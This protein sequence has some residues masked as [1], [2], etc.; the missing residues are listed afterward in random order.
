MILF[1]AWWLWIGF[2]LILGILEI[3]LPGF[4]LLGFGLGAVLTGLVI[5]SG[6]IMTL[7]NT[8]LVFA[9]FSLGA[10]LLLKKVFRTKYGSAKTFDHDINDEM[11]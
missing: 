3:L 7:P 2:G 4:I 1:Q 5:L 6:I 9:I 8:L 10:W 11:R